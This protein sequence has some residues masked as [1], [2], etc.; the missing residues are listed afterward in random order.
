M[1]Y[2]NITSREI[3]VARE[4]ASKLTPEQLVAQLEA[5][6]FT[7]FLDESG[8]FSEPKAIEAAPYGVGI[9]K[10]VF[11]NGRSLDISKAAKEFNRLQKFIIDRVGVPALIE[12][13]GAGGLMVPWA[14]AFPSPLAM[15]STFDPGLMLRVA[16]VI[17]RQAS[18]LGVRQ[19]FSPV[20]D[21]C[22]DPRWGRCEETYGEDPRL[23]AAMGVSYVK[24][25]QSQGV[26]ATLK[27]FVAYGASEGGRNGA[28]APIGYLDLRNLVMV[29]FEAAVK[30]SSPLS[31]MP[32]YNDVDGVPSHANGL[33][34]DGVLRGEWGFSGF[35]VSDAEALSML[36]DTQGVAQGREE[37]ALLAITSG[38]DVE[39]G[40]APM[41]GRLYWA[42]A[43]MVRSGKAPESVIRRAA[44]RVVAAKVA[45]GLFENPYVS[46]SGGPLEEPGDRELARE[47]AERSVV[48]LKNDGALP[49]RHDARVLLT[50]PSA[51]DGRAL[52][53]DY[54]LQAH[55]GLRDEI[56]RV[57]SVLEGLRGLG[58]NVDFV[59]V[60]SWTNCSYEEVRAV[61]EA[62]PRHDVV[63]AVV[64]EVAGGFWL[65]DPEV[66]SGEGIDRDP[67]LPECQVRLLEGLLSANARLVIIVISGRPLALPDTVVE[68]SSA[69]LMSFYAGEEG[70]AAIGE[71]LLGLVNPSGRLPVTVPRA[72]GDVPVH[73]GLRAS[74]ASRITRRRVTPLFPF[75]HGLSYSRVEYY[76]LNVSSDR[77]AITL[78]FSLRNLGPMDV[79]EVPQLYVSPPSEV[80]ERPRLELLGFGRV[81]I[82]VGEVRRVM[83][84]VRLDQ[85]SVYLPGERLVVPGGRYIF[86]VGPSSA[87]LSLRAEVE[88]ERLELRGRGGLLWSQLAPAWGEAA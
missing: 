9:V 76:D 24:G 86:Y 40:Y 16:Q 68:R 72:V 41:K 36:I 26:A 73:V 13:E 6:P 15:A 5:I 77:D 29:P 62:A 4:I 44:E 70:G 33:L 18:R 84:E 19:L 60:S 80:Y 50:G 10:R 47:A 83:F 67:V 37:A 45:L 48:L 21:L 12:E 35:T 69:I 49:L 46:Y 17:G 22:L 23:A 42:L 8:A 85:L 59:K 20:L 7:E 39:N 56:T 66:T 75:G 53:F 38:V 32:S 14:T 63:V 79:E 34:I 61:A 54:H 65:A 28:N 25:E 2:P 1:A 87:N 71:V 81:P 58:L 30:E 55:R 57:V 27:H 64:G 51:A 74:S 3:R 43:D 78:T 82:K 52:L 31:V 11:G 88:V